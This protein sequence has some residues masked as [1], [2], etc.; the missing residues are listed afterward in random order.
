MNQPYYPPP[1]PPPRSTSIV[2][3]VAIVAVL[4]GLVVIV[5]GAIMFV[6]FRRAHARSFAS[7]SSTTSATTAWSDFDSPIP[8]SSDDPNWGDRGAPI[9]AVVFADFEDPFAARLAPSIDSLK[10][11]YGASKVRIVWK[12]HAMP[13][14]MHAHEAAE[15]SEGVRALGGND[16]F[17]HFEERAFANQSSLSTASFETWASEWGVDVTKL[18]AGMAAHDWAAKIADDERLA[19]TIGVTSSVAYVNGIKVPAAST[20]TTWQRTIDDESLLAQAAI[21]SGTPTDRVYVTRSKSN[22]ASGAAAFGAPTSTSTYTPPS[23]L[24]VH[25]VPIGSSPVLGA[26]DALVTI[27][28]FSDFQCPF[29]SRAEPTLRALR[30]KYGGDLR[31]VWKNEPLAFHVH[32][33]PAAELALEAR[34][35]RGDAAFWAVH[36]DLYASQSTGLDDTQLLRI[37]RD[38]GVD[39]SRARLAMTSHKF[40]PTIDADETLAKRLGA[41]GTPTFFIN[42]RIISGAQPQTA[43]ET[44]IDEEILKAKIR[45][46]KGTARARVYDE[47]MSTATD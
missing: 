1:M 37:A 47:I 24:V 15:T 40:Q 33:E 42:G 23:P 8:V 27:V 43:F 13:W 46:A 17:F 6:V 44:I 36:D 41:S 4:L 20:M 39:P 3:I 26:S 28:E 30:A 21:A 29:C 34:T 10:A 7:A 2:A 14:H 25:K 31:I 32:A 12:H 45:V 9:T 35:E 18:R 19:T 16:A 22:F 38:H 5:A 11:L